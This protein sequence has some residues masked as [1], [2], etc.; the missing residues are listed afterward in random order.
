MSAI[1]T[2]QLNQNQSLNDGFGSVLQS[3]L[4]PETEASTPLNTESLT[5]TDEKLSVLKNLL[6]FLQQTSISNLKDGLTVEDMLVNNSTDSGSLLLQVLKGITGDDKTA[7]ESFFKSIEELDLEKEQEEMALD[8]QSLLGANVMDLSTILKQV[9][10]LNQEELQQI[11]MDGMAN[12]LKLIKV[13]ELLSENKDMTQDEAVIQKQMKGVLEG[14]T[15][16]LEKWLSNQQQKNSGDLDFSAL[17]DKGQNKALETVK[18]VFFRMESADKE[19]NKQALGLPLQIVKPNQFKLTLTENVRNETLLNESNNQTSSL[20]IQMTKLEQLVLTASKGG[21][22]VSQDEFVKQFESILSKSNFS[23]TN[24]VNK[25]LIRLNPEHLGSLRIELIQKNGMMTARI[26]AT[27]EQAKDML[28]KQVQGL[29]QAFSGQNIQIEKIE[30][31][32]AFNAYNSEKHSQKDAENQS[33]QQQESKQD[34]TEET[35]SEFTGSLAEALLNLE[36]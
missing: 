8:S 11:P 18:N 15:G 35:E 23:G 24:G 27:T 36:V 2:V 26:L 30:I 4:T 12:L 34:S 22:T 5:L 6:D 14:I 3:A 31:S 9:A 17:M 20:Q 13:Q 32:Q 7:L 33:R 1:P 28:E 10:S 16:K 25:L 19:G 29:K 21:Q